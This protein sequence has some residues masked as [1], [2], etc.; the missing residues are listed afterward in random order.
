MDL[1]Y[2]EYCIRKKLIQHYV[3]RHFM[4]DTRYDKNLSLSMYKFIR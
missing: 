1:I 3:L 4:F 2:F